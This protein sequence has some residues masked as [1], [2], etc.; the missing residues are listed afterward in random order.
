MRRVVSLEK[1]QGDVSD[2]GVA[3]NAKSSRDAG[4]AA[5]GSSAASGTASEPA[6][7]VPQTSRQGGVRRP[8]RI[9]SA[10]PSTR[11]AVEQRGEPDQPGEK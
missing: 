7:F 4:E 3:L 10:P 1:L 9:A 11:V 6:A 5:H 2:S 8:P